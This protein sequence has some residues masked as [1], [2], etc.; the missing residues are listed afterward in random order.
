MGVFPSYYEPWG[1]TPAECTAMGIPNVTSN[2]SGFGGYMEQ[3]CKL[4]SNTVDYGVYV[5]DR[6]HKSGHESCDELTELMYK[7]TTMSRRQ[8]II[9][10][11]RTE[12]L[13]DHLDWKSLGT[14]YQKA[15][16][17]A[18]SHLI[19]FYYDDQNANGNGTNEKSSFAVQNNSK[20]DNFEAFFPEHKVHTF[21]AISRPHSIFGDL[22]THDSKSNNGRMSGFQTPVRSS[23]HVDL[24]MVNENYGWVFLVS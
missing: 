4:K 12:R 14:C 11:N 18:I 19:N 10:R 24:N 7:F 3:R 13:S 16:I 1:Y 20:T 2:L 23:S 5:V 9:M 8:R 15:R 21:E 6:K 22:E 17:G